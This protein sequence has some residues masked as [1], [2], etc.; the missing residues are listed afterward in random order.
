MPKCRQEE[1]I[2]TIWPCPGTRTHAPGAMK[3]IILVVSSLVIITVYLV[4]LI[5]AWEQRI[6]SKRNNAF[7]LH[8]I[9]GHTLA[10]ELLAPGLTI[11]LEPSLFINI[12]SLSDLCPSVEKKIFK[13]VMHFH[14]MTYMATPQHKNPCPEVMK[15]TNLEEP[16]LDIIT[17]YLVC[18]NHAQEQRR[19]FLN[20]YI[21]F[22]LFTPKLPPLETEGGGG[23]IKFTISCLLTLQMLHTKFY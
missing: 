18:L 8:D 13:E 1:E 2:F 16:S 15:F 17:L 6:I 12:L 7:S 22:R 14:Y 4:S 21:N 3:F 10:Q 19:R 20:K 23:V 5:C 11:L 9:Y